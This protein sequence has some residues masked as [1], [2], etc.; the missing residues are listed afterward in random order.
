MYILYYLLVC[1][2]IFALIWS[3]AKLEDGY[4]SVKDTIE[5]GLASYCPVINIIALF[6]FLKL[7]LFDGKTMRKFMSKKL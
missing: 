3:F 4:V 6:I 2:T 7:F 5:I 1:T